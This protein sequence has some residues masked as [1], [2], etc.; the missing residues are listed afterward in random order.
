MVRQCIAAIVFASLA[1]G[2]AAA[3]DYPTR[4][5]TFIVPQ[6]PG[7]TTDNVARVFAEAMSKVLG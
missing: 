4:D 5:I 2:L 7:G 6:N 3:Q 1:S